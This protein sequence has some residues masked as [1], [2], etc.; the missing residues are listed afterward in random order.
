MMLNQVEERLQNYQ[1]RTIDAQLPEAAVLIPITNASEP[2]LVF[3]R[4]ATHMST[5]SGEV[6][7]P[8]GKRD[9]SDKDLVHT[10]LRESFEEIALPPETVRI[11]GQ[12][13]SVISRF[14]LEVTPIVGIIE[15]DTPLRA[16]MAELDRIFKVPLSYFLDKE[17]LTFNHWKMRNQDYM[18]P[19]FYYGEYLIWG[20]TAVMLVE[21][22][23]ITLD[24][25]IPL[26]AP[27]FNSHFTMKKA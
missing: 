24:A 14:G 8:G 3:T 11:I 16:N 9:P 26:N 10:A 12:T 1:P 2:E 21:F 5:H 15:A 27:H 19:S 23:N 6:A 22:L 18:M 7:F 17:N 20:L 13:G 4:R 25:G